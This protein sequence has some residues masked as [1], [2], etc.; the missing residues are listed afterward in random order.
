MDYGDTNINTTVRNVLSSSDDLKPYGWGDIPLRKYQVDGVNWMLDK[1]EHG[2]GCILGDEMGLG[3]TCQTIAV[4]AYNHGRSR[5]P[6]LV[7][8][9]RSVLENWEQ[10]IR[11][12]APGLRGQVLIGEKEKRQDLAMHIKQDIKKNSLQFD[13]LITTYEIC[14]KDSH[15]LQLI[16]WNLLIVDEAHRLKNINSLLHKTLFEWS[17]TMA[18]LLTGTPIQNNLQELY[19]LLTFVC[20]NKFPLADSE[21]FVDKFS[22]IK[23]KAQRLHELLKPYLLLRRKTEVLKDIP[24][25]TEVVLSHGISK[26]QARIYKG[27]LMKDLD[28]FGNDSSGMKQTPRLMNILMNLRKCVN[29]PYLFD[30]V[31]PEPFQIGEHLVEASA[32]LMLIDK[33]LKYL[34][35]CGHKVLM[36]SQMTHMLDILQDYLGYRGYT[37]ERL[38]GSVRG[39]ERFLAIQNFNESDETFVF[40]LSTRAGGQ[41]INLTSADTVIFVD[42]D[43]NPQNDRQAAARAH[44]IGQKRSVKIIRLIGKNTVEEI[45]LKRAVEKLKLTETV[46]KEGEFSLGI[47]KED[48][49]TDNKVKLQDILMYGVD[50]LFK[51]KQLDEVDLDIEDIIGPTVGGEWQPQE[52]DSGNEEADLEET[53][54]SMYLFE[55]TD[56]SKE[57]SAADRKKFVE[58][59]EAER[60]VIE[61]KS[62]ENRSLRAKSQ[63]NILLK[64]LPDVLP[65][66]R[67]KLSPEELEKR[68]EKLKEAAERKARYLEEQE[69][70]KAGEMRKKKD[71]LWKKANY[72][73]CNIDM[74]VENEEGIFDEDEGSIDEDNGYSTADISTK[75]IHYVVGDVTHPKQTERRNN[76]IVHCADDSGHWGQGGLFS[77]I[78]ARSELPEKQYMLAGDM[79]DLSLGDCHLIPFD[80][81]SSHKDGN[82]LL[83]LIIA[84]QRDKR[85][86]LSGIKMSALECGLEKIY[87]KVKDGQVAVHLPRIGHETIGFNWYGTEKLIKKHL[88]AKGIPT[89]IYYFP[90]QHNKRKV[91]ELGYDPS[92][93]VKRGDT[94]VVQATTSKTSSAK[95]CLMSIFSGTVV[96]IHQD[97]ISE[98]DLKK[99]KRYIIAYDGDVDIA[100]SNTTTHIV[101]KIGCNTQKL[102]EI[103][104]DHPDVPVVSTE[105]IHDCL[106]MKILLK[107]ENYEVK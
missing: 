4:L 39:E 76:V 87:S 42:S 6:N 100:V 66:T 80:D 93:K 101:I 105:W 103:V 34:H 91:A 56:Y 20:P 23:E 96:Y 22:N 53:P 59:I 47:S 75:D 14:M 106:E 15:F 81:T 19:A 43:F 12:F 88:A 68:K 99:Y 82:D 94:N 45:I 92:S 52:E 61:T 67:K 17:K 16:A 21:D 64:G 73:S 48:L 46:I 97:G 90:R 49:F 85:N 33:L 50:D 38:D 25:K 77:A 78:S 11:R 28:V 51:D 44:R 72:H 62:T 35:A 84:Q 24:V 107:T 58:M 41:G 5:L 55:G 69:I 10:E 1:Y 36:F 7:V 102:S 40:L 18:I 83:A 37:Y 104:K 65:K 89:Y 29:H 57:P 13:V 70:R 98:T 30:G 26:L 71:E 9:P 74:E 32:K 8:C 95:T 86:H 63:I 31:E 3:K 2:H 27:I 79:Q 54:K 60:A